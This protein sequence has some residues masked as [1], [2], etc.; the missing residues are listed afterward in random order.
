MG[1]DCLS[2]LD[3]WKNYK[4]ILHYSIYIHPRAGDDGGEFKNHINVQI[5]DAPLIEISSTFIRECLKNGKNVQYFLLPWEILYV[6]E[7]YYN[8]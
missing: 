3:K 4:Q 8:I 7:I 6:L 2:E 1:S 5:I